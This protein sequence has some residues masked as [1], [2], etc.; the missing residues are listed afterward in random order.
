MILD[1]R[2]GS[3]LLSVLL[4]SRFPEAHLYLMDFSDAMLALARQRMGADPKVT[5]LRGDYL[6]E[7]LPTELCAVVSSLSIHHLDDAG[8]REIFRKSFAALKQDGVFVNADQV[9]GP[10][11]DLDERYRTHWL[12]QIRAAGASE[13]QI[14]DSLFRQEQDR[15]TPVEDQLA[16]MREAGFVDA[17]CWYKEGRFAVMAG[18]KK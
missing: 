15:C 16:W 6:A 8:K 7:P 13:Q 3:G 10:T 9:A 14:V 4:R 17:D 5:F 2:A 18:T 1:L 11:P 12:E